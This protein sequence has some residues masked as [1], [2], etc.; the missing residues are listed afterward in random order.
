[1]CVSVDTEAVFHNG[2]TFIGL[3]RVVEK[4]EY[5]H[6]VPDKALVKMRVL[7]AGVHLAKRHILAPGSVTLKKVT[8]TSASLMC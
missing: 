4:E 6:P 7:K 8:L 5:D 2:V 3:S 1:M